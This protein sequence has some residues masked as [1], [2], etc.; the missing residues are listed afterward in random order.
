MEYVEDIGVC[1]VNCGGRNFPFYY[2]RSFWY[3]GFKFVF[4]CFEYGRKK[5]QSL[6]ELGSGAGVAYDRE[7]DGRSNVYEQMFRIFIRKL[8]RD[9]R[10]LGHL[11]EF[12]RDRNSLFLP[13][14]KINCLL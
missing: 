12:A 3:D 9:G 8:Q 7:C 5:P 14:W 1:Y 11:S 2:H 4:G 13:I 6:I 10:S